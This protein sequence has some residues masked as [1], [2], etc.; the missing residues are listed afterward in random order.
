PALVT[1]LLGVMKTGAA[2]VALDPAYPADRLEFMMRDSGAPVLLTQDRLTPPPVADGVRIIR[3]DGDWESIAGESPE[4]PR[5]DVTPR[6]GAYVVYT[7]GSTG[8]PKGVAVEHAGLLALC[9]WHADAFGVTEADRAT[10]LASPGFDASAWELWPYLT[11]GASID[12]VPEEVRTDP[13]ALRDWLAARSITV[14]FIPTPVAEPLL[15][16][17]WPASTPLRWMLT[18]GDRLQSR[19][20]IDLPFA[21]SN[22]YGPTECT[23]VATSGRVSSEGERAPDIGGP[24]AN[25]RVYVL[26]GGMRVLPAGIPGE[27]FIGGAQV[28]RGY[29][30]RA[31]LTADRFVPDPFGGTAG[32]RLYRS[33]DKVRWLADGTIEYLGRLDEQ[34]KVRGFRIE[35]GEV[36][37][38]LRQHAGVRECVVIAR[39]DRPGDRRL[40][41]Y[42]VGDGVSAADLRAHLRRVLPDYMVPSAFLLLD[43]LPLTANGK[44]DRKALPAP[45]PV[46]AEAE[47]VAPRTPT[48][49]VLAGILA[50][51][52]GVD[53]V[54]IED[55]F[56]ELGGHSLMGTRVMSRVR[57]VLGV[58]LPLRALFEGPTVARLAAR[59]EVIRRAGQPRLPSIVPV[60]RTDA[61]PLSFAQERLWFLDQLEA[62]SAFY[63]IPAALRLTGALDAGA[64]ERALGEIVR[65]H[66]A[67]RTTFAAYGGIPVQVIAPF[68]GFALPMEDLSALDGAARE[69]ETRRRTD[70]EAR[71]PFDLATG[72]LFRASL[73]RLADDEHVLLLCMHHVVSDGWSLDVLFRELG[74]LY[75]AFTQGAE[76][77]LPELPVQYADFAVWQR[78]HLRGE[79]LDTQVAWWKQQLTGAPSLLELPTDHPR[80]AVQ[81]YRGARASVALSP[82]LLQRLEALGRREGATLYMV[83]LSAFQVLLAKYAGSEDVVVGSPSAGRTRGEVEAL[84]GF[85]VNTLVM[86]TELGGNPGFGEVLR[87]VRTATLDAFEHQEVP[88]ERLVAELA[89]E[90]SLS[91]APLVQVM[92]ALQSGR[93]AGDGMPGLRVEGVDA[94][95]ATAK[96][97]LTLDVEADAEG[98]HGTL[99]Y[100]T[101]LFERATIAR[102]LGH[103]E[104]VLEQVA[105]DADRPIAALELLGADERAAVV[106]GW[107]RTDAPYRA[108]VAV[109]RW[110]EAHAERAP[111]AVAVASADGSL[112][113]GAL[114]ERANRLAHHLL[115]RGAGPEVRVGVCLERGPDL[116]TALL[117]VMKTGAA[118]VALDPAYPAD[119]LEFMMR[120]SGAPVLLTQAG[121]APPPL[122]E[123]VQ[124]IR[125]DGDWDSIASESPENPRIEVAPRTG[126]YVVYTS[127]STGTPKGVAVEHAGLAALCAWHVD[128]FGVTDADRA[129]Q[130]ASP[131]FDASAWELWPYLTRGAS[132]EV[133]PEEVRADPPALRDWLA[134]RPITV[135][136]IPTP[137][138]E[139]LLALEWPATTALR[140]MLTGGDR[141][142]SRPGVELPFALS[143]NY[144]PTECTVVATS[145]RVSADGERA[146]DIGGPVAN[147]RVY[148]LD[149]GMRPMPAG[150]PGELFIGGA[151]VARGYL[152]R[153]G[154]TADRFVPDPFGGQAGARLYRSGDKVR[155]LADGTI[156]YLGRLDE[157]V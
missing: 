43:A 146:P 138:A 6:N 38:V 137:V 62:Q 97:D 44:L 64:L 98:I 73:L 96:F 79:A 132:V 60:E 58:E 30:G 83:L 10:Q 85:F 16:L 69:A 141:L 46:S 19:P 42:V 27:L 15:A 72:P 136:F 123:G 29:L 3:I 133:V 14:S 22:N 74:A 68:A 116:V 92:F 34:V 90:R 71:R 100:S 41:A 140:W 109:H 5:M 24:I 106:D 59:V 1:A 35:L 93:P 31:G 36:E 94:A 81:R 2:Y 45:E 50:E 149:G 77:P 78:E 66:E 53:R 88:F 102:M 56:F 57:A 37:A 122:G 154:L 25:T 21:L 61:L 55:N 143:N 12:V 51:L 49:E 95:L 23:V 89:P 110:F 155:W 33:G 40:A 65:R 144:G 120:D 76:S 111:M 17:E 48:E 20:G 124:V 84:I 145:G 128:A 103:L 82:V 148:V 157:Q 125:V 142:Q 26:D 80:P 118:Y 52:L 156:E 126:A 112:T 9:A 70:E 153:A 127:G 86:R 8:T 54:G 4:N 18:G 91:H 67:L 151:Q 152:G 87:R 28:A 129:T 134:A 150:I 104:R 99:E 107:N 75:G 47:Y 32:A 135:A 117:G 101:D 7:S 11:R 119:R 130:I 13:P 39:E 131:G 63:N 108:D 114:N 121:L 139:P 115:R 147:T 105:E 113:Y